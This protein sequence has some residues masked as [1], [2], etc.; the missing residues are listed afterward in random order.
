MSARRIRYWKAYCDEVVHPGLWKRWFLN[1][2]VAVGWPIPWFSY[3]DDRHETSAW[4]YVKRRLREIEPGDHVV[5]HLRGHCIGRIGF[6]VGKRVADAQWDPL[7]PRSRE[8]R[9]GEVGRRL[10]VRWDL[11]RGPSDPDDVVQLPPSARLSGGSV[12]RTVAEINAAQFKRIRD[13]V[14][15]ESNW[16]SL[17]ARYAHESSLSDFI[18]SFPHLL[19][20]GLLPHS[21]QRVR[22]MKFPDGTRADVIVEDRDRRTVVIECKQGAP[23]VAHVRQLLGYMKHP[24][25][26]G[27]RPVRAILVHGCATKL[28]RE[29]RRWRGDVEFVQYRLSVGF[30]A[31]R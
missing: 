9:N 13:A 31:C 22:E 26:K 14:C 12:R 19:E 11:S 5:V 20:D 30:S 18:A 10:E 17:R 3:E 7:D 15:D 21:S 4:R 27:G 24:R 1:Q 28:P 29:L 8:E 2:C 25:K 16:V 23:T 6:I